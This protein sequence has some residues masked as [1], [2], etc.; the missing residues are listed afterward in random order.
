[1]LRHRKLAHQ[2]FVY[3]WPDATYVHV[4]E[5]GQVVSKPVVAPTGLRADGHRGVRGVSV[6]GLENEKFWT[7]QLRDLCDRSLYGL[8]S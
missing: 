8:S 4:S 3:V 7:E 2:P 6:G 5:G 1:M